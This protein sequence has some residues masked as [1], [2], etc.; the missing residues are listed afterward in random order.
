MTYNNM[1]VEQIPQHVKHNAD[2]H[3]IPNK[4]QPPPRKNPLRPLVV[5]SGI[6]LSANNPTAITPFMKNLEKYIQNLNNFTKAT[7]HDAITSTAFYH[8]A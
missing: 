1:N 8:Y 2:K 3:C 4:Y 5:S 7:W 6:G